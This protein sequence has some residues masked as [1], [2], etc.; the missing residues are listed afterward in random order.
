[1]S[2]LREQ[3]RNP[4]EICSKFDVDEALLAINEGDIEIY[5][6]EKTLL[7]KSL[8]ISKAENEKLED[9][10]QKQK[11]ELKEINEIVRKKDEKIKEYQSR[12]EK[13][14]QIIEERQQKNKKIK[15]VGLRIFIM[16]VFS[17][18]LIIAFVFK[19]VL[20]IL[21]LLGALS[22]AILLKKWYFKLESKILK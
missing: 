10:L 12:D 11:G 1:M 13:D 2:N 21:T 15:C 4:E 16:L 20:G 19:V 8:E 6:R 3:A 18:I 17:G 5:V 9:D 22:G 14:T 7:K